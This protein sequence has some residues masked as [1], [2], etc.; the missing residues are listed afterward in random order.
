MQV[1]HLR[2]LPAAEVNG[3]PPPHHHLHFLW[4]SEKE[5]LHPEANIVPLSK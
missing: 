2:T 5:S 3:A 4:T 1:P